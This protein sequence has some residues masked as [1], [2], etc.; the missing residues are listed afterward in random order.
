MRLLTI[1]VI[2]TILLAG[3]GVGAAERPGEGCVDEECVLAEFSGSLRFDQT[4][5][6]VDSSGLACRMPA[7]LVPFSDARLQGE[8]AITGWSTDILGQSVLWLGGWLIGDSDAGWVE[9]A[10]PRL[11]H[12]DVTPTH[13]TSV[14]V[15]T[16]AYDGLYTISEVT[17]SGPVFDFEGHIIAGDI[18]GKKH[19][20]DFSGV[21]TLGDL[22]DLDW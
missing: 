17:V 16:G 15:G 12:A 19:S 13:Y 14:F 10:S 6:G 2:V 21:I 18:D 9:T 20:A 3:S 7:V 4:C 11:Q 5:E 8:V 1:A 22:D